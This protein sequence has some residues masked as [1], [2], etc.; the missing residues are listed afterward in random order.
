MIEPA[1]E[2]EKNIQRPGRVPSR[3]NRM[4][5]LRRAIGRVL[6]LKAPD[7]P[8][9]DPATQPRWR[10][11]VG[12]N[13]GRKADQTEWILEAVH[14]EAHGHAPRINDIRWRNTLKRTHAALKTIQRH[15][16][17]PD[18]GMFLS[19]HQ[20]AR[21]YELNGAEHGP[22]IATVEIGAPSVTAAA[23][24]PPSDRSG[25]GRMRY[26]IH[27]E[28]PDPEKF[29]GLLDEVYDPPEPSTQSPRRWRAD[30]IN[31]KHPR[32]G[33]RRRPL[34]RREQWTLNASHD[35][36][37]DQREIRMG[38]IRWTTAE[39]QKTREG[40]ATSEADAQYSPSAIAEMIAEHAN[41]K[42]GVS[43]QILVRKTPYELR[44]IQPDADAIK[45]TIDNIYDPEH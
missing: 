22:A 3:I 5:K 24:T 16:M 1:Q 31:P 25:S 23:G 18:R 2:R 8:T 38:R 27:I 4:F 20:I 45:T 42:E 15:A 28:S 12:E 13:Y 19:P 17:P 35:A 44:L 40:S 29:E 11:L 39:D 10:L 21:L 9:A 7:K 41:P 14:D 43:V 33:L 34:E 30:E 37:A 36:T 26:Q 6:G 32:W